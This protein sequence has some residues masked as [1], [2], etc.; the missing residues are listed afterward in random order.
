MWASCETCAHKRRLVHNFI[1]GE[2][3][4]EDICCTVFYADG[5]PIYETDRDDVCERWMQKEEKPNVG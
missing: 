3:F 4:G 1:P 2:G 5:G